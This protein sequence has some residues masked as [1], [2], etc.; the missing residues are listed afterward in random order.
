M[1]PLKASRALGPIAKIPRKCHSQAR[2]KPGQDRMIGFIPAAQGG[3]A[4]AI[5]DAGLPALGREIDA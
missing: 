5:T 1:A 4:A 3:P 2:A